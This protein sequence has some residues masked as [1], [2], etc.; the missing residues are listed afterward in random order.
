MLEKFIA[1]ALV[2]VVAVIV[3]PFTSGL[4]N[5][6]VALPFIV[7]VPLPKFTAPLAMYSAYAFVAEGGAE[8]Y[9]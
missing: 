5:E 9:T 3:R 6:M 8:M 2:P 4:A 1:L 7:V